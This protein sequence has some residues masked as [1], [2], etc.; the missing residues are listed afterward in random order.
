MSKSYYSLGLMSGTSMDGIDASIIQSDGEN[1]Y[2]PIIDE[3]FEYPKSIYSKLIDLKDKV[4]NS[5]DLN[6]FSDEIKSI[7]K[8]VTILHAEAA[9]KVIDKFTKNIDF[10]GFHGQTIFHNAKEKISKQLGNAQLLSQ[11]TKKTVIY[12]FRENDLKNGGEGA[13]LTPIFHNL[14]KKKFKINSAIFINIGGIIN[15]T[16]SMNENH[17]SA[18][19]VGPGMC[20]ID[21]W[22]RS[23]SKKKYDTNGSIAKSGKINKK[24]ID[25]ELKIFFKKNTYK[26]ISTRSFDTN[27]FNTEFVNNLSIEDGAATL[28][29][30]SV[31]ILVDKLKDV[32]KEK[33][34]L[35]G[36]GRKNNFL[37]ERIK[38]NN[39]SYK[40][41]DE[42]NVDGDF[43]ESQAFAYIAIR[44]YLNL[45]ISFPK[46]TGVKLPCKGGDIIQN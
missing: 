3:Y 28:I 19:D 23:K 20:L 4:T 36:G 39:I 18:S 40:L 16:T 37:I 7:E 17:L 43:I 33:I 38:K 14:L 44:K 15:E 42:F 22:I 32:E 25:K 27:D 35:C 8:E 34:I 41:I 46:T 24:I 5:I 21:K 2:N 45:P 13:P 12:N 30:F 29:E 26:L 1:T 31:K 10:I 6:K 11:L 9:N